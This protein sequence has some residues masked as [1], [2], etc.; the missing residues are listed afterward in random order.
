MTKLILFLLRLGSF[1]NHMFFCAGFILSTVNADVQ[2][3]SLALATT[4]LFPSL[5]TSCNLV[6]RQSV[7]TATML[8]FYLL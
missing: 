4:I 7:L 1:G 3:T 6:D 2:I 8:I 5:L